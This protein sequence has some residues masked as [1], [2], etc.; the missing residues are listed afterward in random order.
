[1]SK[2]TTKSLSI[3]SI[4]TIALGP[5]FDLLEALTIDLIDDEDAPKQHI[6]DKE[7]QELGGGLSSNVEQLIRE[8]D[9]AFKAVGAALASV[10]SSSEGWYNT[11]TRLDERNT[12]YHSQSLEITG[13]YTP[14]LVL[15]PTVSISMPKPKSERKK[16]TKRKKNISGKALH[17]FPPPPGSAQS[18]WVVTEVTKNVVDVGQEVR[19]RS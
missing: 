17:A 19:D 11:D 2:S 15:D 14:S 5:T 10:N 16:F 3:T 7:E 8:T 13:S 6:N 4:A 9:E 18:R 12:R 1:L